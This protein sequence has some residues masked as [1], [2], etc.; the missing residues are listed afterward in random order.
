M[1]VDIY[2]CELPVLTLR[3]IK[4]AISMGRSLHPKTKR[5]PLCIEFDVNY[6]RP[7]VV[8]LDLPQ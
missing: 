2:S 5:C 1:R 8:A 7:K 3:K 4:T 6:S